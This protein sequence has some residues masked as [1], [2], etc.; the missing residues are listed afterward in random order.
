MSLELDLFSPT[1]LL[2]V[3]RFSEAVW[4]R[5]RTSRFYEWRYLECPNQRG[6]LMLRD[7]Q[8]LAT[9]W[10]F[11]RRCQTGDGSMECLE[12]LDWAALPE[13]AGR[14]LG[15]RLLQHVMNG[16]LPIISVGGSEEARR[17]LPGLE[18]ISPGG[19]VQF[20]LPLSGRFIADRL[21]RLRLP[22]PVARLAGSVVAH[23]WFRAGRRTSVHGGTVMSVREPTTELPALYS[24]ERRNVPL[25][26]PAF[27][28]WVLAAPKEHGDYELF[29]FRVNGHLKGWSFIRVRDSITGRIGEI[30]DLYTMADDRST[31]TGYFQRRWL[32][33]LREGQGSLIRGLPIVGDRRSILLSVFF[34]D[35]PYPFISGH[36]NPRPKGLG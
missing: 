12:F 25:P 2:A 16:P 4:Q 32:G 22:K 30:I 6:F 27:L 28:R 34:A 1:H 5:P 35:P 21:D 3:A 36:P 33:W 9:A 10:F 15:V 13:V 7:G 20:F 11:V 18:W 29:Y 17:L 14:G 24:N 26:D 19:V 23:G 8:C 31:G